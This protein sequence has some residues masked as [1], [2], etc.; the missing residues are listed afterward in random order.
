MMGSDAAHGGSGGSPV[1]SCEHL[2]HDPPELELEL[3]EL[4]LLELELLELLELFE[5]LELPPWQASPHWRSSGSGF[6]V[7]ID[8][9]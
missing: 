9:I 8:K 6:G 7:S 2:L 5:L 4:E 1:R 3:F